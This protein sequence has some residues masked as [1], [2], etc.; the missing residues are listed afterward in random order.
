MARPE[1]F[2]LPA[3]WFVVGKPGNPKALQAAPASQVRLS[4]STSWYTNKP[5][6]LGFTPKVVFQTVPDFGPLPAPHGVVLT[7]VTV[8][9]RLLN[10]W[11]ALAD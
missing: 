1:S 4:W 6:K 5:T 10:R 9:W 7:V 2:E 3:F 11:R 8:R